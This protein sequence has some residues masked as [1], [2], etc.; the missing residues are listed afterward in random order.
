MSTSVACVSALTGLK[1]RL[2]QSLSQI[3]LRMFFETGAL[4]PALVKLAETASMRGVVE[5]SS[6]PSVKRLPST[7][8]TTPGDTRF[9]AGYATLPITRAASML[10]AMLP[11]GSAET[12]GVP[13]YC[14]P[15]LWKY[16]HG[17]P[18]CI[19]TTLVVSWQS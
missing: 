15:C 13:S 11:S 14:P 2:P 8:W 7:T 9:A 17:I 19:V 1:L 6:S 10:R 4:K 12:T 18:F 3:S 5:P 16:H